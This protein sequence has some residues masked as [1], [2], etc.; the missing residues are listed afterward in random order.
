MLRLPSRTSVLPP[1]I[2]L[3][4]LNVLFFPF[5]WGHKSLMQSAQLC[6]SVTPTGSWSGKKVELRLPLTQDGAAAAWQTEAYLG[7]LHNEYILR[8]ELPLW[9]PFQAL[10]EP[11]AANMHSQPFYPLTMLLSLYVSPKTYNLFVLLRLFIAGLFSFYFLRLFLSDVPAYGGAVASMLGGYQ[12]LYITMPHVSVECL[13]PALLFAV[14]LFLR[15]PTYLRWIGVIICVYLTI[16]GGMPESTFVVLSFGTCFAAFRLISA[17]QLQNKAKIAALLSLSGVLGFGLAAFLLIPFWEYVRHSFN[18]HSPAFHSG[19]YKDIFG[20]SILT[21][22]TPLLLGIGPELRNY[23]GIAILVFVLI[24]VYYAVTTSLSRREELSQITLFFSL[25]LTIIILKRYGVWPI[26]ELGQFP[27]FNRILFPKYEEIV[28][29]VCVSALSAIGL[30]RISDGQLSTKN[31]VCSLTIPFVCCWAGVVCWLP[32]IDSRPTAGFGTAFPKFALTIAALCWLATFWT[33]ILAGKPE[34]RSKRAA[35]LGVS[36]LTVELST[37]FVVPA[38]YLFNSTPNISENPYQ[39][40]PY[41]RHLQKS[42]QDYSRIFGRDGFLFPDWSSSFSL[43]DV[44]DVDA[45]YYSKYMPFVRE[46]FGGPS[47]EGLPAERANYFTGLAAYDFRTDLARRFLQLSSTKY[48]VS[49][50][51]IRSLQVRGFCEL[52]YDYDAKICKVS[53]V[54]PRAAIYSKVEIGANDRHILERLADPSFDVFGSAVLDQTKLDPQ[55]YKQARQLA[56]APSSAVQSARIIS[57]DPRKV[58]IS[59][60]VKSLG[61]LVLNDTSYPGWRVLVNGKRAKWTT[62]NYMFRGVILQPGE[63]LITFFYA[64]S[65]YLIGGLVSSFS[66]L[67]VALVGVFGIWRKRRRQSALPRTAPNRFET[68]STS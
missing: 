55:M 23:F 3:L 53:R 24:A 9:N 64:P 12:I 16:V 14:E 25:F 41:I 42:T 49:A 21:Y 4:T 45:L 60:P 61:L 46:F 52:V 31:L 36:V 5:V 20:P 56:T 50:V 57:Y 17:K 34:A 27:I 6:Q 62:A 19:M 7:Y 28:V 63:N 44:R 67:C 18:V 15:R 37:I 1:A 59:A 26:S 22:V 35:I 13:L 48:I 65:S 51:P 32:Y 66:I 11:L 39:G 29:S 43:F 68:A 8:H 38:Y 40:A 33:L 58:E 10:G 2:L 47:N 30:Q 54:L